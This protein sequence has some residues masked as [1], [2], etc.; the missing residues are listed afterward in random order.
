M[1]RAV[2]KLPFHPPVDTGFL[3][4]TGSAEGSAGSP[5]IAPVGARSA[6]AVESRGTCSFPLPPISRCLGS[7]QLRATGRGSLVLPDPPQTGVPAE[8]T[9]WGGGRWGPP[10]P[11]APHEY[12]M[13]PVAGGASANKLLVLQHQPLSPPCRNACNPI[14]PVPSAT[15]PSPAPL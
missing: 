15:R 11:A 3:E 7:D 14:S 4:K 10:C 12:S 1:F 2:R 13:S 5:L 8:G 6:G 9:K